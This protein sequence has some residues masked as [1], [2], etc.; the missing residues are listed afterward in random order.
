MKVASANNAKIA[1]KELGVKKRIELL[2]PIYEAF[3]GK[4]DEIA[5]LETRETGRAIT[6]SK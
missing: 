4:E 2:R 3:K 6:E 5:L 1:W